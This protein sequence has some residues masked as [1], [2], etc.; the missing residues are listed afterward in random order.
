MVRCMERQVHM[1]G[2]GERC[3][4]SWHGGPGSGPHSQGG[5]RSLA[6]SEG[7]VCA[8]CRRGGQAF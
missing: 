4:P 7:P 8:I 5:R 2:K 3:R 1:E 6:A